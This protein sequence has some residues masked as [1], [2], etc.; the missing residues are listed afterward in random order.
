LIRINKG[1]QSYEESQQVIMK[2]KAQ[3]EEDKKIE[4]AYKGHMEEMQCLEVE[5]EALRK[6]VMEEK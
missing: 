2:L 6:E 3:L 5:I 4:K 1:V